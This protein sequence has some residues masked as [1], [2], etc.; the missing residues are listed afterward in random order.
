MLAG[1]VELD[2][3]LDAKWEF[4]RDKYGAGQRGA[5]LGLGAALPSPPG[6]SSTRV[7]EGEVSSHHQAPEHPRTPG[8]GGSAR[9]GE[10]QPRRPCPSCGGGE[11]GCLCGP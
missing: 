10:G 1:V 7:T 9:A 8:R 5:G 2:L 6:D 11:W 3:P 4:P